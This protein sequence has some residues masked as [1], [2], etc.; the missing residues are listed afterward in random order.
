ME[1]NLRDPQAQIQAAALKPNHK[2]IFINCEK[3]ETRVALINDGKL[4]EYQIERNHD[5]PQ[6]GAIYLAKIVNL[7]ESLQA[8]FVDIGAGKNAFLH[9]WDMLPASY[10]IVERI[11]S[12]TVKNSKRTLP[13]NFSDKVKSLFG[14]GSKSKQ[15][16]ES[17]Q[18]RR[19]LKITV[20]D[21]PELFPP[22]SELLVQVVKSPIGSKGA[23]LTTNISIPGRYLVL[24]PY[25]EHI[26]LSSKIENRKERERLRKIMTEL[27]VPENMGLI[28]RTVGEGRKQIFFQRDMDM[29]LDFWHKV[30]TRLQNP[31]VP[32]IVYREPNLLERSVRDF[33]TEDIDD[34]T[35]DSEE[36]YDKLQAAVSKFMGRRLASKVKLYNKPKPIFEFFH[37]K[38]QVQDI[39]KREVQ[40][41]SGGYICIDETEALIAI[42]V[43]TGKGRKNKDQPD[44]I[45]STNLEA[46]EEVARQLRLR[47]IG[48]LVVIDFI[49]MR[50]PNDRELLFKHM[51]RL[52]RNDRAKTKMLPLSRLG[53]MEM[54]RQ[55]EHES[56][57]NTVFDICP[58]CQGSGR[59]KSVLSMSVEIQRRLQEI[60]RRHKDR[61]DFAV[62]V[63][64]HPEVL[65]RLKNEDA[66]LFAELEDKYGKSLT[67]RAD[68]N[69][70]HES[71]QL[72]DPTN[73]TEY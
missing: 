21:I 33:M 22:G 23:R 53:L 62:R 72:V 55:R 37:V 67:F 19:R 57:K 54:T 68:P 49:D 29:L 8:A 39:F 28:C 73:N 14:K 42:D 12:E 24:L 36:Q 30:E 56:I 60:L 9:Y 51:R 38:E 69:I 44:T 58:Y 71:F 25:S 48:G 70:H 45:L 41:P 32:C 64:M 47:N 43:N 34:I 35:V 2:R 10:D 18:K 15:L 52:V 40:L 63:I 6:V 27:D 17:E 31:K 13:S 16:Q 61:H 65:S 11:T 50:S 5:E 3:L 66:G 59:I 4:E 20:K 7:E 1:D 46:A 26:G